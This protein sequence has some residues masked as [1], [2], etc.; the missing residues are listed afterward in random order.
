MTADRY[1]DAQ[2]QSSLVH[3]SIDH[4]GIPNRVYHAYGYVKSCG[5]GQL[6]RRPTAAAKGAR[7][8]AR[9]RGR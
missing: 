8:R 7:H 9:R 2:T 6:G 4:D 1:W 3:F 5:P